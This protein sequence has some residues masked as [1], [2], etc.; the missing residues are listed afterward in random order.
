MAT[1]IAAST[2]AAEAFRMMELSPISSFADDS[3]Q[4]AAAAEQYPHALDMCLQ[5]YDWSFVRR[6]AQ[7]ALVSDL[8][9]EW[10]TDP[11]LPY[12]YALPGDCV[13]L[14]L[15]VDQDI[16]WRREENYIR[17]DV[18]TGLVIRYSRRITNEKLLPSTFQTFVAAQ[19]A[20]LL[21]PGPGFV[22]RTEKV[23]RIE[24]KLAPLKQAAIDNDSYSASASRLDDLPQSTDW[25]LEA[26]R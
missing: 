5:S 4:A 17:A 8:P 25:V 9:T 10:I 19:L 15:V 20:T 21:A 16:D 3:Q 18:E 1:P 12:L 26:L 13:Q 24:A 11:D 22:R 2:I 14:L 7:L 23:D 6:T